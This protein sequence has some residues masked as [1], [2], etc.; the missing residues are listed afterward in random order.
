VSELRIGPL[1]EL[2]QI[3][4]VQD[5]VPEPI[6]IFKLPSG[7]Y[8]ISDTCTHEKTELS[9]GDVDDEDE[10]IECMLHGARFHIP[11]GEVRSL[12]ATQPVKTY[13]TE[14]RDGDVY[15]KV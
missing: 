1:E 7:V 8:A 3:T 4:V 11:T 15:L 9:D 2:K 13:V 5:E 14:I 10:T 12:P 6:A